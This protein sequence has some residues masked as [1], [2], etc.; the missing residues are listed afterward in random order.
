RLKQILFNLVG[1]ALKFTDHGE[2]AIRTEVVGEALRFS[3]IDT[4]RGIP[5][6]EQDNVFN[7]FH[8]VEGSN[9]R[10]Q[11]GTGLGLAISRKLVKLHGG[12]MALQSREG[13]G[14]CFSFTIPLA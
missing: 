6:Q 14:S 7:S 8:Q 10:R 5:L 1:N 9:L 12:T 2:I 13:H 3:V 11:G 4:G